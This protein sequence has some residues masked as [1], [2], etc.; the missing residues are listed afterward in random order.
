MSANPQNIYFP[1]RRL[2]PR[3]TCNYPAR[4]RGHDE[5]EKP[6]EEVCKAVNL[7]RNG[8]YLMMN[9]EIPRGAEVSIRIGFPTGYLKLG[10]CKLAVHGMVVRGEFSSETIYGIAVKFEEY[11]FV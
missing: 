6:Y 2:K 9:R 3:F 11:R 5:N 8:V 4:I 1:E 10:T 7:S